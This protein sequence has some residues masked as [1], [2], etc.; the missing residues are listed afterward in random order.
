[1]KQVSDFGNRRQYF[2]AKLYSVGNRIMDLYCFILKSLTF[3]CSILRTIIT[4]SIK[5]IQSVVLIQRNP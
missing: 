3:V 1:M 5:F 2:V 4:I